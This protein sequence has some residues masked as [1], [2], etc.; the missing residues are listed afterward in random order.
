MAVRVGLNFDHC[1]R[2]AVGGG[3][4]LAAPPSF[5]FSPAV[6]EQV[7]TTGYNKK[8]LARLSKDGIGYYADQSL[9]RDAHPFPL[10]AGAPPKFES[11]Y[12]TIFFI[13]PS[14]L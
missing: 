13:L 8:S 7:H 11:G 6:C 14:R 5:L 9:L 4:V 2:F 12:A 3:V 1:G 10:A